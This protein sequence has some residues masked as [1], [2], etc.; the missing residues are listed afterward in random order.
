MH[1]AGSILHY[2]HSTNLLYK[3]Y[4]NTPLRR[5]FNWLQFTKGQTR[6][7]LIS[8]NG[9]LIGTLTERFHT[10]TGRQREREKENM[11]GFYVLYYDVS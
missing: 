5:M 8:S 4:Y 7:G 1:P 11:G 2:L 3:A 9:M 6:L 10:E